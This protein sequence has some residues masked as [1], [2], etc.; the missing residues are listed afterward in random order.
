MEQ[1]VSD[2]RKDPKPREPV[3]QGKILVVDDEIGPRESLR[4]LLK[5]THEVFLADHVDAG[6]EMLKEHKPDLVIL[7]IRMPGKSG[8]QGLQELRKIDPVVSVVMLTGFGALDTARQAIQLGANDYLKKPFDT[9]EI[10]K[11]IRENIE[12]T[13]LARKQAHVTEDLRNLNTELVNELTVKEHMACLGHASAEFVHDLRNPFRQA[14]QDRFDIVREPPY[15][16]GNG[17]QCF[18]QTVWLS[19]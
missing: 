6:L 9:K 10:M 3:W 18:H 16:I 2:V 15:L 1:T 12:R 8:I 5:N 4:M 11:V 19:R 14:I 17:R 7:D 13:H